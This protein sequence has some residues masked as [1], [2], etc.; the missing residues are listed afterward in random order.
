MPNLTYKDLKVSVG[1]FGGD[2]RIQLRSLDIKLTAEQ[3]A[4][5]VYPVFDAQEKALHPA[6]TLEKK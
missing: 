1:M 2:F 3:L 4:E 5:Q 6:P